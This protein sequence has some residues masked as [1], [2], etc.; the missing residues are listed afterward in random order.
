MRTTKQVK[1]RIFKEIID[2]LHEYFDSHA[3][4]RL[5]FEKHPEIYAEFLSNKKDVATGH[6]QIAN[7]LSKNGKEL[8]IVK[9]GEIDSLNVFCNVSR[10]SIWKKL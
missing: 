1:I 10:N 2:V 5:L 8:N 4:I 3:F 6:W 9:D 7:F